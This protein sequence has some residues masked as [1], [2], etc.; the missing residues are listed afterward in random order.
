MSHFSVSDRIAGLDLADC[1][2]SEELSAVLD[3]FGVEKFRDLRCVSLQDLREVS[4]AASTLALEL[5]CLIRRAERGE[6]RRPV[7]ETF[8]DEIRLVPA[9]TAPTEPPGETIWIPKAVRGLVLSMF[10]SSARLQTIFH[11]LGFSRA[12]DLQGRQ[13][14]HFL[15]LRNFGPGT[16]QDLRKLIQEIQQA[17][18]E[19][20]KPAPQKNAP[21]SRRTRSFAVPEAARDVVPYDLPISPALDGA[22]RRKGITRLGDLEGTEYSELS[23]MTGCGPKSVKTLLALIE[24]AGAGEFNCSQ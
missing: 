12:G 5:G 10:Q 17:P 24:R 21:G 14:K 2:Q 11:R 4:E 16:L 1:L 7:A 9:S 23:R 13:Y 3:R 6:F 20:P 15:R 18:P 8:S 22:L 19:G